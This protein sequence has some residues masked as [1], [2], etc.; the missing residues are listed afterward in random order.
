VNSYGHFYYFIEHTNIR[1]V[2]EGIRLVK[3]VKEGIMLGK[4]NETIHYYH[5]NHG[6]IDVL[7]EGIEIH[8]VGNPFN[9]Q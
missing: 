8:W 4:R 1:Y 6:E 3:Y 9:L 7:I 5:R 2:K